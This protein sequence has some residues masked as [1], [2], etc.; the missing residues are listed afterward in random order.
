MCTK[1]DEEPILLVGGEN[2]T[3][4]Q[5][6]KSGWGRPSGSARGEIPYRSGGEYRIGQGK[7]PYRSGECLNGVQQLG[8]FCVGK[9]THAGYLVGVC[10]KAKAD[11][12]GQFYPLLLVKLAK[13]L[14]LEK[15]PA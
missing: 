10:A 4:Y 6:L 2:L 3:T 1:I 11:L 7:I 9:A 5:H 8:G 12:P 13:R 14:P 15:A